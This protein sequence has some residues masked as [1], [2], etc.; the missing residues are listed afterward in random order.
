MP[1]YEFFCPN[2]RR[3]YSFFARSLR[4]A[5]KVP[6]CPD[7]PKWKMEKMLSSFAVTGNAKE[8]SE[9]GDDASMDA[10]MDVMEREFG[11]IADT[12]NPDPK[13]I[14]RMMRRMGELTGG[15]M[16]A[17]M[18]EMIAR[19]E[20]GEDPDKLDEEY[21]DVMDDFGGSDEPDGKRGISRRRKISRDPGMYE[22]SEWVDEK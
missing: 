2:N 18:E 15:K 6:R 16:P 9:A 10:A 21:G 20:K 8:P 22:M 7:N 1:I 4:M 14:A 5:D 17:Q 11:S 13:T 3:I 19:M 12:D